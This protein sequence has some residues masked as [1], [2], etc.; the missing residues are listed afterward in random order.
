[1]IAAAAEIPAPFSL[2]S[3]LA[4]APRAAGPPPAV[5]LQ[6]PFR[7]GKLFA[8]EGARAAWLRLEPSSVLR[9]VV[10]DGFSE[11]LRFPKDRHGQPRCRPLCSG[12]A[13]SALKEAAFVRAEVAKLCD[14][15]AVSNVT[16]LRGN[17]RE[18][19]YRLG[20]L[21][22]E[23]NGCAG[24]NCG[25]LAGCRCMLWLGRRQAAR[26]L[27]LMGPMLPCPFQEASAVLGRARA[28]QAD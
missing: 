24:M 8:A 10:T 26:Q 25:H 9:R 16:H 5:P 27:P 14:I 18:V 19:C 17:P 15:G 4:E 6:P 12:H 23:R 13:P 28:E 21:V 1:M 7:A 2:Q 3:M 20:L 22:A 11:F